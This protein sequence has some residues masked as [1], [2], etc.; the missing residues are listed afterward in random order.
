MIQHLR[1]PALLASALLAGCASSTDRPGNT[2]PHDG[3]CNARV[4][5]YLLDSRITPGL[6]ERAREQAGAAH[7][8]VSQPNQAVTL[9][10]NPQ[11]LNIVIDEDDIIIRLNCG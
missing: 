10:Y 3:Q 7:L 8:R 4:V 2:G 6:A 11:R 5:Q 9:D 1:F